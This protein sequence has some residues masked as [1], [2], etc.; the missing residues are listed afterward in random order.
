MNN[1]LGCLVDGVIAAVFA[2]M[3]LMLILAIMGEMGQ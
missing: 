2:A 3:V 1:W